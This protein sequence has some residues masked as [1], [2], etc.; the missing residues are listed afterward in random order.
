MTAATAATAAAPAA[1][2]AST[3]DAGEV[4]RFSAIAAEWWNPRGKFRPLHRLNPVRIA[5]IR[6]TL[7]Q[8]FG[9]DPLAPRPLA[10]LR[11]VDIGCGGGLLAEPLARLGAEMVAIDAA[12]RNVRVAALHAADT[13]TPVDY[14]HTTAEELAAAGERFDAVLTLEVIEH[15]ADVPLFLASCATLLRP[16]GVLFLATLNRTAKAWLV[17]IAGAEYVL[18]WL[19]RGTHDWKKFLKP[20]EVAAALRPLG[21]EIRH[22]TGVDYNPLGD[23]FHLNPRDLSVNYLLWAEKRA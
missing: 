17:A 4:A 2:G 7:C 16:G 22:L 9:R 19:P 3:V 21:L 11:L 20:S 14:R 10:G 23:S 5:Y 6:D 8:R 18:R 12:E 1:T 15:V 13:G